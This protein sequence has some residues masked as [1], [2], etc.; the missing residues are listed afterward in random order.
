M[1]PRLSRY[2]SNPEEMTG[3]KFAVGYLVL[4]AEEN[5][6][7]LKWKMARIQKLFSG[8]GDVHGVAELKTANGNLI[9]PIIKLRR[10]PITYGEP[11]SNSGQFTD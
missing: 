1:A 5:I 10:L 2:T 7:P 3:P 9:R 8:N 11:Q 4:L 6:P